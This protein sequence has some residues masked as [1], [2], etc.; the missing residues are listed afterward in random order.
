MLPIVQFWHE[1]KPP[2]FVV[3]LQPSFADHN[4]RAEHVVFSAGTAAD[5]IETYFGAR[6]VA[7]FGACAVPAMQADYFRYCAVGA[8][9]GIYVD[10][11]CRCRRSMA[12]LV[13]PPATGVLYGRSG[14]GAQAV[15][16]RLGLPVSVGPFRTV[17][18]GMF[19]FA[20]PGH[21]LLEMAVELAT[22]SIESRL[23]EGPL[24]IWLA[25]G[26]GIFTSLY[27]LHELGSFDAF[28]RHVAGSAIASRVP[29]I[30]EVVGDEGSLT[31][32]FD[33]IEIK[34]VSVC[35]EYVDEIIKPPGY[36]ER[37]WARTAQNI[38]R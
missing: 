4:P 13:P 16:A 28:E 20:G 18:N 36:R 37:H 10:A 23:G 31:R 35:F 22:A 5:L 32:A 14:P 30:R 9:G 21:P 34:P 15:S 29:L 38:Y 7:A 17:A 3:A 2:A 12:D 27:L 19:A 26:P 25:T 33:G 24:G 1:S 6:E 8:L 11:D